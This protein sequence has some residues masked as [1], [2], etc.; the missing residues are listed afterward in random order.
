MARFDPQRVTTAGLL[1]LLVPTLH[2]QNTSLEP[3][4]NPCSLD[5]G[6]VPYAAL[7]EADVAWER[8]V[9]RVIDLKDVTNR[10]FCSP[11]GD[12][13]QCLGLFGVVRH[14]LLDEGAITAYDPGPM[15][16]DDAFRKPFSRSEIGS[17]VAALDTLPNE[18]IS[19]F[20][21]KEDWIFDKQRSKMEV[22]IIGIAPMLELRGDDGELRGHCPL[23]WLYY[24][25]CR[26]LFSRWAAALDP[27]GNPLSYED[28]FAQRRFTSTIVKM[29]NVFD[30]AINEHKATLDALLESEAIR[31]QVFRMG[32]DLWNY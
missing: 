26:L 12:L 31:E 5:G 10:P 11:S 1:F 28:L 23:F 16:S 15:A 6:V 2:A 24:P 25:E 21:I 7:R 18:R 3:V 9:W 4:K 8:R 19:R 13:T 29:S 32:F 17:V 30:R 22:R 27:S 20:M 14:G